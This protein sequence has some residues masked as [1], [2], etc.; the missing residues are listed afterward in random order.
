MA[1]DRTTTAEFL[2]GTLLSVPGR[3]ADATVRRPPPYRWVL[4]RTRTP[5]AEAAR[6]AER[7]LVEGLV[8]RLGAVDGI[9]FVVSQVDD[10]RTAPGLG[11]D[12]GRRLELVCQLAATAYFATALEPPELLRR[13]DAAGVADWGADGY[14]DPRLPHRRGSVAA[15]LAYYRDGGRHPDG[16]PRDLPALFAP[17]PLDAR[18]S[19]DEPGRTPVAEPTP[20][21]FNSSFAQYADDPAAAEAVRAARAEHGRILR[22][23]RSGAGGPQRPGYF[24]VPRG[25]R[26]RGH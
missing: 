14:A 9:T 15:A 3:V 20:T 24:T 11:L 2:L 23:G 16:S 26:R 19:W 1:G 4:A 12:P 18:L 21:M 13:I 5:G 25:W 6:A 17:E 8:E 10:R 7:A 22:L